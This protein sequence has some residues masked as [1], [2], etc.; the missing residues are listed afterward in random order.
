M[1]K[2]YKDSEDTSPIVWGERGPQFVGFIKRLIARGNLTEKYLNILTSSEAMELYSMV[3]TNS[4]ANPVKNYEMMEMVGDSTCNKCIVWYFFYKYPHLNNKEGVKT[5]AKLKILYC[6]TTTFSMIADRQG[7]LPFISAREDRFLHRKVDTM[8]DCFEA[9]F[10]AT[11]YLLDKYVRQGVGY[12]ICYEIFKSFFDEIIFDIRYY[13][14]VDNVTKLK[15]LVDGHP[16]III[17]GRQHKIMGFEFVKGQYQAKAVGGTVSSSVNLI[18]D[19]GQKL[20]FGRG[21]GSKAPHA[22]RKAAQDALRRLKFQY[23]IIRPYENPPENDDFEE[24]K[25]VFVN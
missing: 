19:N 21:S 23:G 1:E 10:G 12:A 15:E 3:F 2:P 18:L 20:E 22:N 25:T 17:N 6:A 11:E 4:T 14:L 24:I 8:E 7:F 9:F 5:I 16:T 13:K